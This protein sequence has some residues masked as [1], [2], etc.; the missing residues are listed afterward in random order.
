MDKLD[1]KMMAPRYVEKKDGNLYLVYEDEGMATKAQLLLGV[2]ILTCFDGY[3]NAL[4]IK[5]E[6]AT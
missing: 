2:G 5:L 4:E 3:Y 1:L 6:N